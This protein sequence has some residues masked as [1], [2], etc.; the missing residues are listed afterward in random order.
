MHGYLRAQIHV[1]RY[2]NRWVIRGIQHGRRSPSR[3]PNVNIGAM[4]L[5][6]A[7]LLAMD[8]TGAYLAAWSTN[9]RS[10]YHP[11]PYTPPARTRPKKAAEKNP[12]LGPVWPSS[13]A[14]GGIHGWG[15][16]G[17]YVQYHNQTIAFGL[18]SLRL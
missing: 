14:G 5:T 17:L 15:N 16:A 10:R 7:H 9:Y 18:C 6:G 11:Q 12:Y 13:G 1:C 2:W 4:D 3:K 8:L